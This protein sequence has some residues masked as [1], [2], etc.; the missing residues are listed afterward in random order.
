MGV[1]DIFGKLQ[2]QLKV[3]NDGMSMPHYKVGDTV[4]WEDGIYIGY[5]GAIVI[6]DK[7][8]VAEFPYVVDKWGNEIGCLQILSV[9]GTTHL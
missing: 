6:K 7:K 2:I 5:E 4:D 8:F 9:L 1:Y 3:N